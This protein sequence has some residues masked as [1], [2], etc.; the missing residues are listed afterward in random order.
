[1]EE[2]LKVIIG[3]IICIQ[4]QELEPWVEKVNRIKNETKVLRVYFNNHYG[5]KGCC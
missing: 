4:K 1:M 2:I 3:I 5:G